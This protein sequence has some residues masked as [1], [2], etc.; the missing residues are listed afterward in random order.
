[1]MSGYCNSDLMHSFLCELK[2]DINMFE[3]GITETKWT[4]QIGTVGMS[5]ASNKI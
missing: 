2:M 4:L 5:S 1:V 3:V